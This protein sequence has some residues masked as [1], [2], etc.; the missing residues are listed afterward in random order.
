MGSWGVGARGGWGCKLAVISPPASKYR[1]Q[2]QRRVAAAGSIE[3][4][5]WTF[6]TPRRCGAVRCGAVRCG[7]VRRGAAQCGG[8]AR[9]GGGAR[10]GARLPQDVR[11]EH[12]G[13]L[14]VRWPMN[15]PQRVRDRVNRVAL[16]A[17]LAGTKVRLELG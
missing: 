12:D 6:Y 10:C 1:S 3:Q 14:G 11:D 17:R 8:A 7:A 15:W 2:L 4:F 16:V 9:C 5:V 13:E